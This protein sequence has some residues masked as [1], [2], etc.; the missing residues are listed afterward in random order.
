MTPTEPTPDPEP[1]DDVDP[2][3]K[4]ES[5]ADDAT[6]GAVPPDEDLDDE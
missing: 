2:A 5:L 4:G 1:R 6:P 3:T